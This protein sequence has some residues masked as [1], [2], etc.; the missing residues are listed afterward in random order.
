MVLVEGPAPQVM[1]R[2]TEYYHLEGIS[3]LSASLAPG[4]QHV[5]EVVKVALCGDGPGAVLSRTTTGVLARRNMEKEA[6]C[7][8]LRL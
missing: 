4:V 7:C 8:L 5:A 6:D 2:E 1:D 3:L